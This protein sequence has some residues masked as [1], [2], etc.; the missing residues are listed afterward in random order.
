MVPDPLLVWITRVVV[1]RMA[2]SGLPSLLK[3]PATVA[4]VA[5]PAAESVPVAK[6][7]VPS[8]AT[9]VAPVVEALAAMSW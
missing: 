8:L 5:D 4:N 6:A 1:P 2:R 3:S 7:P 9:T